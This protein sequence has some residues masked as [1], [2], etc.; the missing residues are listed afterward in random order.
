MTEVLSPEITASRVRLSEALRRQ[1]E[2]ANASIGD[3]SLEADYLTA[4]AAVA[5]AE[6]ELK[7]LT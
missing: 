3:P 5:K 6:A 4:V 2:L 1:S 7:E